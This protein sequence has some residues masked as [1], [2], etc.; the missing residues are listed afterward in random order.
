[1]NKYLAVLLTLFIMST[2]IA[3]CGK[4]VED[5]DIQETGSVVESQMDSTNS[6]AEE[7]TEN[8]TVDTTTESTGTES[9]TIPQIALEQKDIPDNEAMQFVEDMKLGWNLGNTFDAVD[10]NH[11]TVELEYEKVWNGYYTTEEM[12]DAIKEA[13]FNTVRLPVS[14]HNHLVDDSYTISE[15]WMDRVNEVVDWCIER[16]MYVILNIHHDSSTEFVYPLEE[17]EE[18]SIAYLTAIWTQLAERYKDYDEHLLFESINEPRL[19]GH[20]FEWWL[21]PNNEDCKEA[22]ACINRYNQVFVDLVRASGGN[23]ATRY[24]MCPGYGASPD[25]ALN[26][27]FILPTDTIENKIIV[28]VHAYTPYNFALDAGGTDTWSIENQTDV[29]NMVGF[30]DKLYNKFISKGV[31]VIIGE[32]GARNKYNNIEA[33]TEFAAYYVAAA[34]ARGMTCCW[35]DNNAFIGTG[36]NFGLLNR[37]GIN[38]VYPEIVEA[39]MAYAEAK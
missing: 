9:T 17:Y 14:W 29:T 6:E 34:R 12:I 2:S 25:G 18:Q 39:M 3:A 1:M 8:T 37:S 32:F 20:Q 36:E 38:W 28:S 35:W 23:N 5:G 16:D 22:I 11:L 4:Q 31:A 15:V 30:M 19:V 21:N 13:G 7:T 33:R 26:N 27:G 10:A 24:L